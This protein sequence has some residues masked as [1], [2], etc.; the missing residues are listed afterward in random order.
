VI[1]DDNDVKVGVVLHDD[2][3][4]VAQVPVVGC[5]VEGRNDH[6]EGQFLVFAHLISGLIVEL[7]ILR[8]LA[9][10]GSIRVCQ[11]ASL[12]GFA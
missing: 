4:D 6:A 1:V 12:A 9:G 11:I 8:D 3:F 10:Q 5:V 2:G 7:L